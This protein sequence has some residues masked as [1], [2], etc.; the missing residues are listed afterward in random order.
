MKHLLPVD[1]SILVFKVSGLY[2]GPRVHEGPMRPHNPDASG[3]HRVYTLPDGS[4][5]PA[6]SM[7]VPR[8]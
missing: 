1:L 2:L 5:P 4:W 3:K 8:A 6:S 7:V